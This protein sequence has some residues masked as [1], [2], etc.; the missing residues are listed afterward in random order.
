M[1]T[2]A[3]ETDGTLHAGQLTGRALIG[4][5][6]SHGVVLNDS[7]V[8][9]LHA[10]VDPT[11]DGGWV[12]TDA[13]SKN[14][15]AVNGKRVTR[16]PLVDGDVI[17]VGATR[18]TFQATEAVPTA[19]EAV[20]LCP[21]PGESVRTSGI[22]FACDHCQAPIWVGAELA[23]KR[24]RCRHCKQP[25]AV[26]KP[27]AAPATAPAAP[28]PAA[29]RRPQ[30]GVC[31]SAIG[32][33]EPLKS[34]PECDTTYHAECWAENFGCST[35]GCGQ[36]DALNPKPKT[37]KDPGMVAPAS[38][39]GTSGSTE[40]FEPPAAESA[41]PSA[42]WEWLTVLATLVASAVGALAFGVPALL[43]GVVAAVMLVRRKPGT[44]VELLLLA[45]AIALVG[46]V[47]GLA[48]SDFLYLNGKHLP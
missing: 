6:L 2:L 40:A 4:R 16:Q 46:I 38:M 26:P 21:P 42:Q 34:C 23:G 7:A 45:L 11:P 37:P 32:A 41:V 48:G 14:G 17:R 12:V 8:S 15:V 28:A 10:W 3:Y 33:G 5:R 18:I 27:S 1:P 13:G 36:V 30:C 43:M 19:A 47:I 22:L 39:M 25:V 44:R 35:Y 24:G 29:G 9:R 20:T 31:H